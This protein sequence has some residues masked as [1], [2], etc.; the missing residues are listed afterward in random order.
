MLLSDFGFVETKPYWD[1]MNER[2]FTAPK[3]IG[4]EVGYSVQ[5]IAPLLNEKKPYFKMRSGGTYAVATT[6]GMAT[7]F[8]RVDKDRRPRRERKRARRTARN[9]AIATA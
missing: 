6:S 4:A 8:I 9:L 1:P 2:M 3:F 7:H 5:Q